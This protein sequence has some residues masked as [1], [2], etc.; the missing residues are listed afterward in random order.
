MT[1]AAKELELLESVELRLALADSD[2]R[3][4]KTLGTFLV[5]TLLKLGSAD[6]VVRNKVVEICTHVSKRL[7]ST[8]AV[9]V[10]ASALVGLL[11]AGHGMLVQNFALI[12]LEMGMGRTGTQE[13]VAVLPGLVHKISKRHPAQQETLFALIVSIMAD[14]RETQTA[15]DKRKELRDRFAWD[16]HQADLKFL[17]DKLL[18]FV[19]YSV[20]S[21]QKA[22]DVTDA[23]SEATQ[24]QSATGVSQSAAKFITNSSKASWT[25]NAQLLNSYKL[26]CLH[27]VSTYVP[28][29]LC[30]MERFCIYLIASG[31]A[32]H[33][34]VAAGDDGLKRNLKPDMEN[35]RMVQ[36]LFRLYL[37]DVQNVTDK[38]AARPAASVGLKVKLLH[39]LSKSATAA[40][41]LPQC[42]Q[43]IF[44]S[45]YG[46]TTPRLRSAGMGFVQWVVRQANPAILSP[47][48]AILLS[49]L[50]KFI[51]E[52]EGI[53]PETEA[54]KGWA[55]ESAGVLIKR[56]PALFDMGLLKQF[57]DALSN[58]SRNVKVSIQSALGDMMEPCRQSLSAS[59][60]LDDAE[61]LLLEQLDKEVHSRYIALKYGNVLFPDTYITSKWMCLYLTGDEKIE[62]K[63]EAK[64]GLRF[65]PSSGQDNQA[66]LKQLPSFESMSKFLLQK[67]RAPVPAGVASRPGLKWMGGMTTET[68]TQAILYLRRLMIVHATPDAINTDSLIFDSDGW[69]EIETRETRKAIKDHLKAVW[70]DDQEHLKAYML[71]IENGLRHKSTDAPLQL[72]CACSLLELV[73][74]CPGFSEDYHQ[75][76]TWLQTLLSSL[77]AETRSAIG[78]VIGLLVAAAGRPEDARSLVD[79][80]LRIAKDSSKQSTIESRHGSIL[81]LGYIISRLVCR[82]P[83]KW[84]SIV[85]KAVVEQCIAFMLEMLNEEGLLGAGACIALGEVGMYG[86]LPL[87]DDDKAKALDKL[88]SLS[89]IAKDPKMHDAAIKT[90]SYI[91]V[92]DPK[93]REDIVQFFISLASS[94]TKNPDTHFAIGCAL[95]TAAFG[96][97]AVNMSSH[98]ELDPADGKGTYPPA[99]GDEVVQSILERVFNELKPTS[100]AVARKSAAIWLMWLVKCSDANNV[101]RQNVMRIQHIFSSLL[102]DRDD[103]VQEIASKGMSLIFEFGDERIKKEL[104][105]GLVGTLVEGKK[106]SA[107]S[108]TGET[109]LFNQGALGSTPGEG[110]ISGTYQS[111][112]SLASDMNQPDLVYRFMSLAS[113]SAIWNSRRGASMGFAGIASRAQKELEPYL[114]R[115]VPKLFRMMHDPNP[116]VASSMRNIWNQLVK[117]ETKSKIS[118]EYFELILKECLSGMGDRQWRVREAGA[119]ALGDLIQGKPLT[120]LLPHLEEIWEMTFRGLDDIKESVRSASVKT[121][122]ILSN[123]TI[124][125]TDPENVGDAS[126]RKVV[127]IVVPLLVGKGVTSSVDEVRVLSLGVVLKICQKGNAVLG[128]R[129]TEVVGTLLESLTGFEP[130]TLNY[131]TFHTD[132]YSIT[133]DQLDST[134]LSATKSSPT[135]A[136]LDSIA[137]HIPAQALDSLVPRLITL[138]KKG[139]GLP[140]RAGTARFVT[141]VVQQS[142]QDLRKYADK[143]LRALNGDTILKERS[144]VV[145][146]AYATATGYVARLG[147]DKALQKLFDELHE[148]YLSSPEDE[149]R[150]SIPGIIISEITKRSG[151]V[152]KA[153][154]GQIV[155]LSFFGARDGVD[156]IG[157]TWKEIYEE[158]AAGVSTLTMW[159]SEILGMC[160]KLL[161]TSPSWTVKKQV[162]RAIDDVAKAMRSGVEKFMGRLMP[163]LIESL[164]G[165]TWEGKECLVKALATVCVEGKA[166]FTTD[167]G[168][169]WQDKVAIT[170]L[171][172]AKKNNKPY[173][174]H[175]IECMARVFDSLNIDRYE[176]VWTYLKDSVISNEPMDTHDEPHDKPLDYAIKQNA[177]KALGLCF[178]RSGPTQLQYSTKLCHLLAENLDANVW[179]VRV[180]VIEALDNYIDKLQI[181]SEVLQQGLLT[182]DA[183]TLA[184]EG[185]FKALEDGK[186]SA[187][188]EGGAKV[189]QQLLQKLS[190]CQAIAD[191]VRSSLQT[192]IDAAIQREALSTIQKI[193]QDAKECLR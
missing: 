122:K 83:A 155:P 59:D 192:R 118:E 92:G 165:R 169:P 58:E 78:N 27:F 109:Q 147:S 179:N 28:S 123:L 139:V 154:S 72:V 182:E 162:G 19:S 89:K 112:L 66:Y 18:E 103:F 13:R 39:Y 183:I 176:E 22:N 167:E 164:N 60:K 186:Y 20:P 5:P 67:F 146:K 133:Q 41:T 1:M 79:A 23:S 187:I 86:P 62:V 111:I 98:M 181:S 175:S 49:G 152:I 185:L 121:C 37:G 43:V 29:H 151:D 55:Y 124:R 25:M 24:L 91:A 180:G 4:E 148:L 46:V 158:N 172:E 170:L 189:L 113:H 53:R 150:R 71:L 120:K 142:P 45:L 160:E 17:L 140:T 191:N 69:E 100:S 107:Q 168:A 6:A 48:A 95:S 84:D 173:K 161:E 35:L 63:E 114:P 11:E 80:T 101:I 96:F 166:W 56:I 171:R 94:F 57:F 141:S 184:Y 110:A 117:D 3:F 16:D 97:D 138:I 15:D 102:A 190:A 64:R 99:P 163:L 87:A 54:L 21:P 52:N 74:L 130:Q 156:A 106:I 136:A 174:R 188:R 90:L 73:Q 145:R 51:K 144:A 93:S 153:H 131:L 75:N 10:P 193:L 70:I 12:Y 44:D 149:E 119:L 177:F 33:E 115:L 77:R 143:I 61:A 82:W 76:V 38:S 132:R 36:Y 125:Y 81:A 88:K 135:M 108:V 134:R 128:D 105:D 104:V 178:P 30:A 34:I 2:E 129:V 42:I 14:I 9:R 127:A 137:E 31:D 8:G 50:S 26:A 32:N 116:G 7:K 47:V 40:S 157:E 126:A 159:M 65:P 68:Y 85:D